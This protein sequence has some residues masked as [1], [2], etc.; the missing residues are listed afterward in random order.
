MPKKTPLPPYLVK[1][2]N[3]YF[4][5]L[6]VPKD[7]QY[8]IG[9]KKFIKTTGEQNIKLAQTI[10]N[11]FVMGW[12]AEIASARSK[13][14]EPLINSAKEIKKLL[15]SSPKYLVDEV[16]DE[17]VARLHR[18]RKPIDA[19]VF[20]RIAKGK[21]RH[22]E[23]VAKEWKI[24]E[25][26]RGLAQKFIDQMSNDVDLIV[27]QFPTS[28]FMTA[29]H[30]EWWIKDIARIGKLSAS[31]VT[32]IISSGK[33]FYKYLQFIKEVPISEPNPFIVPTEFKISSKPNSKSLNKVQSWLPFEPKEIVG[34]YKLALDE[35]KTLA[36]L[37]L[38]AMHTGARIEEICSLLCKD[39]DTQN[40]SVTIV[41]AKTEAGE[42]TIPIHPFI[43]ER[44]EQLI[45]ASK[46]DYLLTGLT[47]NKYGDRSNAIG[48]RF[49]RLKEKQ[50]YS[51]RHV[52]HSIRKTFTTMLENAGVGENI[53][54]DIVGH[55]KPRITY[56][57]YSG[58]A[59]L[60][61]MREAIKSVV[62]AL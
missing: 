62:Y 17:E 9:K 34:L 36:D 32:R 53:A 31:S 50:G 57:L 10:A 38:I 51:S 49:G 11:V 60:E 37:M 3:T 25:E 42:R 40:Q 43:K 12:K 8:V 14:D 46:D 44:V 19:Q 45:E 22:L 1:R 27:K 6:Y 30:I 13:S 39:I 20:E 33:N 52:F 58:G 56:G 28:N 29:E 48:K 35:S 59:S 4:A 61:V 26:K 16:I 18:E 7:I 15:K 2:H 5:V 21:N 47:K 55:E 24:H 54:A 23:E 41:N